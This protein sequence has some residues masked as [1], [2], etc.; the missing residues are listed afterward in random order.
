MGFYIHNSVLW[1]F[2]VMKEVPVEVFA[3]WQSAM[4]SDFNC[5]LVEGGMRYDARCLK[6]LWRGYAQFKKDNIF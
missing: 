6:D 3:P 1:G 2:I 5:L 4:F